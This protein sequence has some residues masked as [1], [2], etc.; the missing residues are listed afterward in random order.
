MR[1]RRALIK[2]ATYFFTV[3]LAERSSRLLVD[4]VD[5]LREVVRDV[6]EVHPFEIVAWVVLPEHLHAAWA[7]GAIDVFDAHQPGTSIAACVSIAGD[8]SD[9]GAEVQGAGGGGG[10]APP[11]GFSWVGCVETK[12]LGAGRFVIGRLVTDW[13][14]RLMRLRGDL[15]R[16]V[17][18]VFRRASCSRCTALPWVAPPIGEL[19][20]RYRRPRNSHSH[21]HQ[22]ATMPR[23]SF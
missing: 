22:C 15:S 23:R 17:S 14:L 11:F 2:D 9:Q 16:A 21:D 7:L 18:R 19:R 6:R 3:N 8:S 1:C 12:F 13:R 5:D 20:S 10:E 4:R